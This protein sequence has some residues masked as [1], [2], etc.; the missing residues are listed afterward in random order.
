MKN[1]SKK[2]TKEN[3]LRNK[4]N[5][6]IVFFI[7]IGTAALLYV[8]FGSVTAIIP[9]PFFTRMTP[10]GWL[11]QTSLL[12]TS[13]LF[14]VYIGLLY[15]GRT[16]SKNKVCNA[17]ATTGGVFGFLTF[18]CSICNKILVFFLG[19]TGVL[20]YFE[21]IR[22]LLGTLSI[23]LLGIAVFAKAKNIFKSQSYY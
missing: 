5:A 11:E 21:P 10:V 20:T 7:A 22:P 4:R 16:T 12:M 13:S 6:I 17:T 15:Y 14:G 3:Q 1:K 9:N 18:G 2:E 8:I 19:I 23:G